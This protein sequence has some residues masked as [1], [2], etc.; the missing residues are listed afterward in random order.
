MKADVWKPLSYNMMIAGLPDLLQ[1]T[2]MEHRAPTIHSR[3][4]MRSIAHTGWVRSSSDVRPQR[5]FY[6]PPTRQCLGCLSPVWRQLECLALQ[7]SIQ[8]KRSV[9]PFHIVPLS[10][11]LLGCYSGI[12]KPQTK[13]IQSHCC[14]LSCADVLGPFLA[15][16]PS[17]SAKLSEENIS[18]GFPTH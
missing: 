15:L 11:K 5:G 17:I 13:S 12:W 10:A 1:L 7:E 2:Q 14:G 8:M 18:D 9:R 6:A 3:G 16:L 4:T